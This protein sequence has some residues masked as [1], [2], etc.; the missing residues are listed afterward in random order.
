MI[1]DQKLLDDL[2][3][4][5]KANP[6]LRMNKDLRTT[7]HDQSQRM[8]N[9]LEP[10]TIVPI[11]RHTGSTETLAIIRGCIIERFYNDNGSIIEEIVMRPMGD[12]PMISIPVGQWHDLVCLEPGTIIFESKDGPYEPLGVNDIMKTCTK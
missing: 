4:Q 1:I 12:I 7:E 5:A 6:R 9:A 2:S 8:L 11:H 10:G 3:F